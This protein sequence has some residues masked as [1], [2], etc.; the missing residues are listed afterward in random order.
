MCRRYQH[1]LA[2]WWSIKHFKGIRETR[3]Q[4]Q[5]DIC[6]IAPPLAVSVQVTI[7]PLGAPL[8]DA[9]SSPAGTASAEFVG[10]QFVACHCDAQRK[11]SSDARILVYKKLNNY[12]KNWCQNPIPTRR[13]GISAQLHG[14]NNLKIVFFYARCAKID[15]RTGTRAVPLNGN[16]LNRCSCLTRSSVADRSHLWTPSLAKTSKVPSFTV[17]RF[18]T[19]PRIQH[20]DEVPHLGLSDAPVDILRLGWK[21]ESEDPLRRIRSRSRNCKEEIRHHLLKASRPHNMA[22]LGAACHSDNSC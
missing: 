19:T 21:L 16:F 2:Y 20:L 15:L 8:S 11:Q 9:Q 3:K 5:S 13:H 7:F 18:S 17:A 1:K 14:F 22:L 10:V 4:D 12:P 6:N